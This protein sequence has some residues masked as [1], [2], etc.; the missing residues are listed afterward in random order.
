MLNGLDD[1]EPLNNDSSNE[2]EDDCDDNPELLMQLET[3]QEDFQEE[4]LMGSYEAK[5]AAVDKLKASFR[6]NKD[7]SKEDQKTQIK[8]LE[9]SCDKLRREGA[10][11]IKAKVSEVTLDDDITLTQKLEKLKEG[12]EMAT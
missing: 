3:L 11:T 8:N 1:D 12:S 4:Y 10:K 7:L 6:G 9:K 5:S 2:E